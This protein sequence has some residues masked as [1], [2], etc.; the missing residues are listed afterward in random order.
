MLGRKQA[1]ATELAQSWPVRARIV[2][3]SKNQ[4]SF[5]EIRCDHC[6]VSFPPETKV[7]FHCGKRL[8]ARRQVLDSAPTLEEAFKHLMPA[9][10][11]A[12]KPD[13]NFLDASRT[14]PD[15]A[16][17]SEAIAA[18]EQQEQQE[19]EEEEPRSTKA[20]LLGNFVWI[21][22]AVVFT[23]YRACNGG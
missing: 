22:L 16:Y 2:P 9:D 14:S 20:R 4:E 12:K 17:Q 18:E 6:N 8:G 3:M 13:S 21:A 23:A 5:F 7:C 1:P 19:E 10:L 11:A 15:V